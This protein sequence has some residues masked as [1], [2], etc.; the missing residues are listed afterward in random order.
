MRSLAA[1]SGHMFRRM[2]R[3]IVII[4][5]HTVW[6]GNFVLSRG[7][8]KFSGLSLTAFYDSEDSVEIRSCL[9]SRERDPAGIE[10]VPHLKYS[11]ETAS[12]P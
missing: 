10:R 7:P 9:S 11:W 2:E 5:R 6:T 1:A 3:K 4:K 12:T 8:A